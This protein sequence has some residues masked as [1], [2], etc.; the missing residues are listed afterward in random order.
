MISPVEERGATCK[1]TEL[2]LAAEAQSGWR[3]CLYTVY[4]PFQIFRLT[5][6]GMSLWIGLGAGLG[7]G[8]VV[9]GAAAWYFVSKRN[10]NVSREKSARELP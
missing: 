8:V 2:P 9:V 10:S 4:R 5:P 6:A 7:G 1:N 3:P